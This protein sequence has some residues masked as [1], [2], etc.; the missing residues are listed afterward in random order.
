MAPQLPADFGDRRKDGDA[1][2]GQRILRA[3]LEAGRDRAALSLRR[4]KLSIRARRCRDLTPVK[5]SGGI[6]CEYPLS[7]VDCG[8]AF[9]TPNL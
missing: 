8:G 9:R 5:G 7:L 3:Q 2:L 6:A 1:S 4:V